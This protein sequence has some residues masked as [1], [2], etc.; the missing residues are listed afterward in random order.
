MF[1]KLLPFDQSQIHS[2]PREP[3]IYIIYLKYPR[4]PVY[5]GRSRCDIHRRLQC[6]VTING[7]RKIAE[8]LSQHIPLEFEYQCMISVEQAEAQ[9]IDALESNAFFNLR[10]EIDPADW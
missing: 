6:H 4:R 10:R 7:N 8:A 9:L 5:V 3:G 1:M 2:V